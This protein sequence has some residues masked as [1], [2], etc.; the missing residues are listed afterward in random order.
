[1][2]TVLASLLPAAALIL[3]SA[4][5]PAP[6][7][8]Q[9]RRVAAAFVLALGRAPSGSELAQYGAAGPLPVPDLVARLREQLARD[10][11]AR[12][13]TVIKSA[14]D[15]FGRAPTDDEIAR[16]SGGGVRTYTELVQDHVAWLAAHPADYEAVLQRAYQ[17]LLRRDPY[18]SEVGYWKKRP[19][20]SCALLVACL[21]NWARRNQPGLMETSGEATVSIN[22]EFLL[23]VPLPPEIAAEARAAVGLPAPAPGHTLI[24]AGASGVVSSGGI[25]FV[26]AGAANIAAP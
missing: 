11:A 20:L 16:W 18:P 10:P 24:A 8:E 4:P 7:S 26:A 25:H 13:A 9:T 19:V 6:S 21:E 2:I 3:P 15:A 17:F 1:M 14:A 22:S 23:V 12:R 5:A